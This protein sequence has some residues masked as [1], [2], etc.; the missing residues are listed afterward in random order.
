MLACIITLPLRSDRHQ[1]ELKTRGIVDIDIRWPDQLVR[2]ETYCQLRRVNDQ[3]KIVE[4][5]VDSP[6]PD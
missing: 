5:A 6:G 1:V 2:M 3:W 4:W